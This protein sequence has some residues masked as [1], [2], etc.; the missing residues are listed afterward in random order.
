MRQY[1]RESGRLSEREEGGGLRERA[2]EREA[3]EGYALQEKRKRG[4][5]NLGIVSGSELDATAT[6]T[7]AFTL[8]EE[9]KVLHFESQVYRL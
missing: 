5:R 8:R 4:H 7:G 9:R 2:C 3:L 1:L 6:C